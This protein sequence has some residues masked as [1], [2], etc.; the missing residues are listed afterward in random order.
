M[1]FDFNDDQRL[2]QQTVRDFLAAECPVDRIRGFWDTETGR[3]PELWNQLA[4]I[5]IPGLLVPE[6]H[7][8]LGMDETD[9]VLLLEETGRAALAEPLVPTA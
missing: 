1:H 7:D 6:A 9:L 4:E 2:L 8:G 5:G 3:S